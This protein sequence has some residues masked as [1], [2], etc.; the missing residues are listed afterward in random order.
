MTARLRTVVGGLT[1]VALVTLGIATLPPAIATAQSSASGSAAPLDENSLEGVNDWECVPAPQHPR[2]VVLVHGTWKGMTTTWESL[3]PQLVADG[4]CVYAL[5]YGGTPDGLFGQETKW[6]NGPIENSADE[7]AAFVNEVRERRNVTQVDVVGHS[8]GGTVTRQ[9]LKFNGGIDP[10]NPEHN[11]VHT[12]VMLAPSTHGSTLVVPPGSGV[13]LDQQRPGSEFLQKLNA[14]RE[15][16]PGI[17]YTVIATKTDRTIIPSESSFLIAAPG[18]SV[19]NMYVQDV[20]QDPNLNLSHSSK[21]I[22]IGGMPG[23]LDHPVA[24]FLVRQALDPALEGAPPCA[25]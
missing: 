19:R 23:L 4:Y 5:N 1:A 24:T 22:H 21:R 10:E 20:C 12:L 9:Y 13:A 6:G 14:D 15:T 3:A 8:Q 11:A 25:G 7:L 16:Y 18:T 17:D 2:P